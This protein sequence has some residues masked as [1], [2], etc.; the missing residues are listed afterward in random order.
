MHNI[1][2]HVPPISLQKQVATVKQFLKTH[3]YRY[4]PTEAQTW[5]EPPVS[6]LAIGVNNFFFNS[7]PICISGSPIFFFFSTSVYSH[8]SCKL[9]C[10]GFDLSHTLPANCLNCMLFSTRKGMCV[11]LSL[12]LC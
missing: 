11:C 1:S 10:T 8:S 6:A 3:T 4:A 2:M 7:F 9:R 5:T 12:P